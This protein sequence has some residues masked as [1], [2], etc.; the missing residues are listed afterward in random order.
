M[1]TCNLFNVNIKLAHPTVRPTPLQTP[2]PPPARHYVVMVELTKNCYLGFS[3]PKYCIMYT[4]NNS[5]LIVQYC[6]K[7]E[8]LLRYLYCY[9]VRS[10]CEHLYKNLPQNNGHILKRLFVKKI[11]AVQHKPMKSY[12]LV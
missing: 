10:Q 8:L 1:I 5:F 2:P 3:S 9:R 11:V 7:G 4:V 12:L 6:C